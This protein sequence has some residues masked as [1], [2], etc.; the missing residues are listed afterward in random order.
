MSQVP[1]IGNIIK[2][3]DFPGNPNCYMIGEVVDVL[4]DL[5][6]CKTLEIIFDSELQTIRPHRREFVTPMEGSSFMDHEFPGRIFI[7]A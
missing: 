1:Q 3:L 2:A 5:I 7:L 4:D 6:R